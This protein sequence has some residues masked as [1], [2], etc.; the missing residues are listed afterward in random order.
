MS[1]MTIMDVKDHELAGI[2]RAAQWHA[3]YAKTLRAAMAKR[4]EDG[5]PYG[6][7]LAEAEQHE[8]YA[9]WFRQSIKD[10]TK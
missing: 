5:V 6:D 9:F 3:D 8:S 10:A 1:A 4:I 2:E 7:Q